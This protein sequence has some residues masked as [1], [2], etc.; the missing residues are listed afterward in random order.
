M[1]NPTQTDLF[2]ETN[3]RLEK[4]LKQKNPNQKEVRECVQTILNIQLKKEKK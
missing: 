3:I 4:I 2:H 1:T